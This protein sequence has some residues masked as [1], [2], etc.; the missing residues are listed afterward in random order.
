MFGID[1]PERGQPFNAKAKE[2][3]AALIAGKEIKVA[4]RNKDRYG[5]FVCDVYLNDGTY[6][7]AE[8]VKAGYAWHFTRYSDDEA[9]ARLQED[10]RKNKRGL[11]QDD[12]PLPPWEFRKH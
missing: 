1:S 5:R 12:N 9:L 4:I 3:T 6:V 7:N 2:F 8:L 11:W 10:A